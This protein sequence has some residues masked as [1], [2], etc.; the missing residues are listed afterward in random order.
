M[1]ELKIR[2]AEELDILN[3]S[4][5]KKQVFIST[6]AIEGIDKDFSNHITTNFSVDKIE[7]DLNDKSKIIL[8]AENKGF[9]IACAEIFLNSFCKET[10]DSSPELNVLYVFEHA[11]GKSVGY[12]LITEAENILKEMNFPGLWLTVYHENM[13]AIKFYQRQ[14]YNDIGLWLFEMEGEKYENRIMF[15]NLK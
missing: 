8:L 3:L 5:L 4:V 10:G 1:S 15:K 9:L 6:Y 11:K 12:K 7:E 2:R 14:S 13:N